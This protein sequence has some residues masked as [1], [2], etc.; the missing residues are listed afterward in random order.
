[1]IR[2]TAT[3]KNVINLDGPDGNV[4]SLMATAYR[5]GKD[6]RIHIDSFGDLSLIHI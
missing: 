1:M 3:P 4:F 2:E 5:L 6:L